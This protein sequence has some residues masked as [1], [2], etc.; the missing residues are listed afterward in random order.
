MKSIFQLKTKNSEL[1]S[2]NQGLTNY[3]YQEV[4]AVKSVTGS[5][6]PGAQISYKWNYGNDKYW[7]PNKSYMKITIKLTGPNNIVGGNI[8]TTALTSLNKLAFSMNTCAGLFQACQ[9]KMADMTVCQ[10]TENLAEVDT[11][12]QRQR[13]SRQW[14]KSIGATTNNWSP[15]WKERAN[16]IGGSPWDLN[17]Q[18]P[19]FTHDELLKSLSDSEPATGWKYELDENGGQIILKV[20]KTVPSNTDGTAGTDID[21]GGT[22]S[23]VNPYIKVG[24]YIAFDWL[25]NN[26]V[27]AS[28]QRTTLS[29]QVVDTSVD[30][31][32]SHFFIRLNKMPNA[33]LSNQ[34]TFT[35]YLVRNVRLYKNSKYGLLSENQGT[36]DLMWKPPLSIFDVQHAIPCAGTLQELSITPFP[37]PAYQINAVQSILESVLPTTDFRLSIEDMRLYLLTCDSN[38][39]QNNLEFMLDLKEVQC[40]KR[41]IQQKSQQNSLDV[42]GST[43]GITIA[44]Q[45]EKAGAETLYPPQ[46]FRIRNGLETKLSRYY[47]RYETQV[48]Q[49][50]SQTEFDKYAV[51]PTNRLKD[52]YNRTNIYTGQAFN[53]GGAETYEEFLT[54]G[55][56]IYHPFPKTASSRN[57]RVYTQ[58]EFNDSDEQILTSKPNMLV[59]QHS[60]KVV[61]VSI[62]NGRIVNV[63]PI[64]A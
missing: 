9:F 50:D 51:L 16:E 1:I 62:V 42:L 31:T 25:V 53:E 11:L 43:N 30:A 35:N 26:T 5:Q 38:K 19:D 27:P 17:T 32:Q 56:Y 22:F 61:V 33:T 28:V 7:I 45:D 12:K 37:E 58:T 20:I 36:V 60:L 10:V 39:I 24:D 47:I 55:M 54:R 41:A 4:Q 29:G 40:Q 48:P 57:T 2:A 52:I 46:I 64:D 6:F 8:I 21:N 34:T 13:Q 15:S 3:H 18:N 14:M 59:F 63:L 44:F 49:P 23:N